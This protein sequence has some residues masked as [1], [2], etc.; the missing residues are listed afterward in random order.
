MRIVHPYYEVDW[1]RARSTVLGALTVTTLVGTFLVDIGSPDGVAAW[2][3]YCVAIVL[4]LQWKGTI[5]IASVTAAALVL[6]VL[7]QWMGPIGDLQTDA[8]NR[9]IGAATITGVALVCLY[10]DR[11]RRRLLH[12]RDAL[13]SSRGR[14]RMFV[15]SL[16]SAGVVLCDL[17]GRITEWNQGVHLLTGRPRER[18]LGLPLFRAFPNH[19]HSVARWAQICHR[20]RREGKVVH[21]GAYRH[22]EGYWCWLHTVV[23]PLRSRIG[24]LQ[25]YSLVLHDFTKPDAPAAPSGPRGRPLSAILSHRPDV[26]R[27]R[28]RF[29]PRRTLDD[30]DAHLA[31]LLG[32]PGSGFPQ[33][34]VGA[35]G[36]WVHPTDRERVWNSIEEA[37]RTRRPYILV[38]RLATVAGADK[39]VWDEGEAVPT[40]EGA[41]QGLEGYLAVIT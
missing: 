28:C 24:R 5:A 16:N 14:L 31:P 11:T 3:L 37:V 25:G 1:G 36:D 27:Y 41:I 15:N 10:V 7:G 9:A 20:A 29:E 35:L 6:M 12:V 34:Q 39:W 21:E 19:A 23:K 40:E 17:R 30:V 26:V 8:T 33:V 22:P 13:A 2:A 38:Y 18:M 4:A 32:D